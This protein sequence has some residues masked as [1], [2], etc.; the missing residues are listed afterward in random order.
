MPL[1]QSEGFV[2]R[3][4]NIGEQDK[5]VVFFSRDQG[6]IKG[7]AKGAR[8]FGNRFGSSLEPF[9]YIRLFYYEKERKELVVFSNS[10]LI[11]S[12]FDLQKDLKTSYTLAFFAELIE[13]FF[14]SN[15]GDDILFRLLSTLLQSLKGG[16]DPDFI[17]VYFEAWFLKI[18]G[19]LPDFSR[20]KKCRAEAEGTTWLSSRKDGLVCQSCATEKKIEIPPD[21]AAFM[22]WIRKNPPSKETSVPFAADRIKSFQKILRPLVVFHMEREPKSLRFLD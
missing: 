21:F 20:C 12:F 7:V 15:S 14:P 3:T 22:T 19:F 5:V 10:D 11:E 2:L 9:S 17:S 13:E 8:K 1:K 16:A 6:L 18:N 4:F